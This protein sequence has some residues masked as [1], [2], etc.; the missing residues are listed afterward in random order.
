MMKQSTWRRV[1]LAFAIGMLV[2]TTFNCEASGDVKLK[3]TFL[4]WSIHHGS[5]GATNERHQGVGLAIRTANRRTFGIM[6]YRNSYG[7]E[8]W[9]VTA[10]QEARKCLWSICPGFGG[11]YAP[12]YKKSGHLPYLGWISFRYK[13][14]TLMTAPGAVTT[15]VLSIPLN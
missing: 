14:V 15:F 3:L 13:W 6:H 12:A 1:L 2:T 4:P 10:S 8:G 7:D 5:N 9:S 11:G